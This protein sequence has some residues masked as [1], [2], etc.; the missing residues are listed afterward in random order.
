MTEFDQQLRDLQQ[1]MRRQEQF[2]TQLT[3][4]FAQ[5]KSLEEMNWTAS[6]S[7]SSRRQTD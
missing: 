4:L 2:Q 7:G 3:S 6:V 5:K 1:Q